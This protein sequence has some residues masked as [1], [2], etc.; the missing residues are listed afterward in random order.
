MSSKSFVMFVRG[1]CGVGINSRPFCSILFSS[2]V[3]GWE[4][5]LIMLFSSFLSASLCI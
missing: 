4:E 3:R 1:L 2:G 5:R